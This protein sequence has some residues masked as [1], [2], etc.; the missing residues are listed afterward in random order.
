[1]DKQAL[2]PLLISFMTMAHKLRLYLHIA[3]ISQMDNSCCLWFVLEEEWCAEAALKA[4]TPLANAVC[5]PW[6]VASHLVSLFTPHRWTTLHHCLL[7]ASLLSISC[8]IKCYHPA[9][10]QKQQLLMGVDCDSVLVSQFLLTAAKQRHVA[11][12]EKSMFWDTINVKNQTYY[13][14]L[15]SFEEISTTKQSTETKKNHQDSQS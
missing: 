13:V 4:G 1:M 11:V 15:Y 9:V 3:S 6:G 7:N 8:Q 14:F 12:D 5:R 10:Q 2:G